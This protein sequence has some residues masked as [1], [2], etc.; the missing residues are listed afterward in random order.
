NSK[1]KALRVVLFYILYCIVNEGVSF[2]LQKIQSENFMFL[3][4]AFTIFEY[5]FFCYFIYLIFSK[6]LVKKIVPFIWIGFIIFAFIDLLFIS[7]AKEFDSFTIGIESIVI[8]LLCIA[9]LFSQLKDSNSTLVYST[10]NFW[11]VITF[12]IYFCGTF[13]LYIMTAG[14]K[15]SVSFQKQYFV[16]NISFNILKNLLLCVAMTMRLNNSI[17]KENKLSI[18]LDDHIYI[19]K[20]INSPN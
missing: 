7:E 4:Y 9:Y 12:L 6:N 14:M 18:E 16:I 11:V 20:Q 3:L 17:K 10:F 1:S 15:D 13:F 19:H 8:I 5:S 2:Y